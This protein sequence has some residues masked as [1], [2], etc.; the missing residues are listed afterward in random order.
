MGKTLKRVGDG[1]SKVRSARGLHAAISTISTPVVPPARS[2]VISAASTAH[3]PLKART[4]IASD[5]RRIT[6]Y[7]LFRR[8]VRVARS[9]RFARQQYDVFLGYRFAGCTLR[10]GGL[11]TFFLAGFSN[12][13]AI[14]R[15]FRRFDYFLMLFLLLTIFFLTIFAIL[16]RFPFVLFFLGFF[17][18]AFGFVMLSLFGKFFLGQ[19]FFGIVRFFVRIFM[20]SLMQVAVPPISFIIEDRAAHVRIRFRPRLRLFM[21]GFHQP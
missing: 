15:R 10:R 8:C 12:L 13:L 21:L 2:T 18:A 4:R 16:L 11:V 3:R 6:P 20:K 19:V 1:R 5:A 7:E 9:P 14:K 17:L